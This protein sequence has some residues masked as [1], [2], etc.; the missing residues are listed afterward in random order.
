MKLVNFSTLKNT[1]SNGSSAHGVKM[2]IIRGPQVH[3]VVYGKIMEI[4]IFDPGNP[5]SDFE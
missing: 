1:S 4:L 3:V 5:G 2:P